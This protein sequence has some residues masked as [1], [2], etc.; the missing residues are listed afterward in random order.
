MSHTQI[1]SKH[2]EQKQQPG[3]GGTPLIPVLGR[4]RQEDLSEFNASLVYK[5]NSRTARTVTLRNPVSKYK[6]KTAK[7][8]IKNKTKTKKHPKTH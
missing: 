3:G 7:Q 4:Q 6:Q 5:A 2:E 8:P 1:T